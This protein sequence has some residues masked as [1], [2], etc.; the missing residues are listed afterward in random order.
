M[1]ERASQ[2]VLLALALVFLGALVVDQLVIRPLSAYLSDADAR[3]AELAAKIAEAERLRASADRDRQLAGIVQRRLRLAAEQEQNEFRRYLETLF[4]PNV[5]VTSSAQVSAVAVPGAPDLRR[6]VYDLRVVGSQGALRGAL[7]HLDAS[8]E[9]LR[10]ERLELSSRSPDDPALV[11][12]VLVS[13]LASVASRPEGRGRSFPP[14][15]ELKL[16]PLA[17]NMFSPAGRPSAGPAGGLAQQMLPAGEFVLVGTVSSDQRRQALLEFP[18]AGRTRWVG[19]GERVNGMTVA[20]V[21]PSEVVFEL[22]GQRLSLAVGSPGADLL[23]GRRVLGGGFELVG[24]CHGQDRSF[25]LVQLDGGA[26]IQRVHLKD[27]LGAGVIVQI[28]ADR[29]VLQTGREQ[30]MVPV[31]GRHAGRAAL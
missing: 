30:Q 18:A 4:A 28:A 10:L 27:R 16:P 8:E 1:F 11:A 31:G 9:L 6:I 19:V 22:G 2:K 23:A 20:Q 24:V 7:E 13:T 21:T 3:L 17:K 14:P 25:A 26:R 5:E 12:N 15:A 29:I